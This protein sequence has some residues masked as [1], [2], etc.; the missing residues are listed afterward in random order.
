MD[1]VGGALS[2]GKLCLSLEVGMVGKSHQLQQLDDVHGN[3]EKFF[4]RHQSNG[5]P[6]QYHHWPM[7]QSGKV[8]IFGLDQ[9]LLRL[10]K[11]CHENDMFSNNI[12]GVF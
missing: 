6:S 12:L 8:L 4:S 11:L 10:H 2:N 9:G 1:Q 3:K 7:N 5:G